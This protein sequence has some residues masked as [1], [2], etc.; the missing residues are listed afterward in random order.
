GVDLEAIARGAGIANATTARDLEQFRKDT[1]EGLKRDGLSLVVAKIEPWIVDV[2]AKYYHLLD[3]RN[4]FVRYIEQ[5]EKI[6]VLRP[7]KIHRRD[8]TKWKAN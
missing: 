2:P 8:P 4:R 5:S 1:E 7:S 6:S 3:D